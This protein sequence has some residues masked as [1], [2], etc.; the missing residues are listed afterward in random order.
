MLPRVKAFAW[1]GSLSRSNTMDLLQRHRPFLQI[2]PNW[3]VLCRKDSESTNHLFM[4]C[5]F[6]KVIWD[7]F[8][9]LNCSWVMPHELLNLF[10]Q[11]NSWGMG[12]RGKCFWAC[13]I[14][15]VQLGIWKERN[16]RIFDGKHKSISKVIDPIVRKL[17]SWLFVTKEFNGL[18]LSLDL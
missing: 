8:S 14:H 9:N 12:V 3:C 2:S 11:R 13:L 4:H 10:S 15:A 18:S 16:L 17:G 1:I 7:H 6:S 5:S